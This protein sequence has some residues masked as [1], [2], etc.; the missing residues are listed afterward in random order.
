MTEKV[1]APAAVIAAT[2]AEWIFNMNQ[3]QTPEP[4]RTEDALGRDKAEMDKISNRAWRGLPPPND[5]PSCVEVA[6]SEEELR[7]LY[8]KNSTLHDAPQPAPSP[9]PSAEPS[10][11]DALL[12]DQFWR[13]SK[14]I[15]LGCTLVE[16]KSY[17]ANHLRAHV[18]ARNAAP[19]PRVEEVE[20]I[21]KNLLARIFRDGGHK[22]AEIGDLK[23]AAELADHTVADLFA[24]LAAARGLAAANAALA[25]EREVYRE[26][27]VRLG[28]KLSD[29]AH[30][31][32][33]AE[34]ALAE[35]T[36]RSIQIQ[37]SAYRS[38]EKAEQQLTA[39]HSA[40]REEMEGERAR[41]V[42]YQRMLD[43]RKDQRF[44]DASP[45]AE[46]P[47]R[48]LEA[49]IDGGIVESEPSQLG[50]LMNKWQA[51]RNQIL[52]AAIDALARQS[53]PAAPQA[54]EGG[55]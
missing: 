35:A 44:V 32:A 10:A 30:R 24:D 34:A 55:K 14:S 15:G 5:P 31:L 20:T 51:E 6:T 4:E 46:L 7:A 39:L 1:F 19:V 9:A 33:K 53:T 45:D 26:D 38:H 27:N 36:H 50:E 11:E 29:T 47:V 43:S 37:D 48:I 18:A 40:H 49:Y 8:M 42:E 17:C 21:T 12:I 25:G 23:A 22:T 54:M 52:R 3:S 41:V 28:L 16:W 2:S 13:A